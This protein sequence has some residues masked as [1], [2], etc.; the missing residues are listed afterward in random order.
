MFLMFLFNIVLT[1]S[2]CL[3]GKLQKSVKQGIKV[4]EE[5]TLFLLVQ[6]DTWY[7]TS[8]KKKSWC[9]LLTGIHLS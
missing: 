9:F 8:E 6:I 1:K 7:L 4:C 2:I 5:L 3:F